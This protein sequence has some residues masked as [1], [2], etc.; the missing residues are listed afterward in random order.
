MK[1]IKPAVVLLMLALSLPSSAEKIR[2]YSWRLYLADQLVDAFEKETGHTLVQMFYDEEAV[3]DA[4]ISSGRGQGFDLIMMDDSTLR[5]MAKLDTFQSLE[6]INGDIEGIEPLWR[7][8]CGPSGVA[9]SWGTSGLM[10]RSSV[11]VEPIHSWRQLF[12]VPAE[13]QGRLV[14]HL[15]HQDSV[16]SALMAIGEPP[17][18]VDKAKLKQ[19]F[20][21]LQKQQAA[22][23][24]QTYGLAYAQ[25]HG[26]S[27]KMSLT[28]G[29][30]SDLSELI[31]V[32]GQDDWVYVVPEEGTLLW[33]DCW[34][35]PNGRTLKPA[36]EAFLKFISRPDI[37]AMNAEKLGF[38][39][40]N[41]AALA[42]A[43]KSYR[44]NKVLFPP[45]GIIDRGSYYQILDSESEKLRQRM[46]TSL[47]SQ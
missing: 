39:T 9:Y 2:I 29:F 38:A 42:I 27:S 6:S 12:E 30:S 21:L 10:Y 23:L 28:Y 44:S 8:A 33:A 25:I 14:T 11:A 24:A 41:Q 43:G 32:S 7:N 35:A 18:A 46:I 40:V 19:A 34:A 13:H 3:R 1:I 22:M 17:F 26:A 16:A 36:T 15:D 5:L 47:R 37:A 45:K 20:Y 4:V 31:K